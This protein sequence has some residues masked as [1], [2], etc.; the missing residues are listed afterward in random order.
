VGVGMIAGSLKRVNL[1][2]G[3]GRGSVRWEA[4][5]CFGY[6]LVCVVLV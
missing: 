2:R 4:L 3:V 5:V 6:P 1:R